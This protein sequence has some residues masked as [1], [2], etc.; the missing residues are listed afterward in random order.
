ML[1]EKQGGTRLAQGKFL[2]D[3]PTATADPFFIVGY[4]RSGTT[5]LSVLLDR[6]SQIAVCPETNFFT[7]VCHIERASHLTDK[8]DVLVDRFVYGFR[9][10][11]LKL[12]R[13][14][15]FK[16]F[17]ATEPN[18]ANLL[19]TA[20]KLYASNH[21]K[22]IVGEKT[23]DHWRFV[24]QILEL[25]PR[26]RV[27][28]IVRDGRDTV[29]SLMKSPS[30]PHWDLEYHAWHWRLSIESM[31]DSQMLNSDRVLRV[32]FEDL[33]RSSEAELARACAF[34]GTDFEPRQLDTSVPSDVVPQ[35]EMAW[36][37]RALQTI[38][39]SRIGAAIRELPGDQLAFLNDI[40]NPCMER[41]G[42]GVG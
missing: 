18:W 42:Y 36:K 15:L 19:L 41:L 12:D 4:P 21:R 22:V 25:F 34:V 38:D 33:L 11:D 17:N 31:L 8:A 2:P 40:I 35:W 28:W 23:P 9:T 13:T 32:N 37:Y 27:M 30:R 39:V 10:R 5:L 1:H 14:E 7:S 29:L 26:S 6:H 3:A 24:P 16:C 20:L